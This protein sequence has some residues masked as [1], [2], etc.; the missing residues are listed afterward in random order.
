MNSQSFWSFIHAVAISVQKCADFCS[1]GLIVLQLLLTTGTLFLPNPTVE[2]THIRT[3]STLPTSKLLPLSIG[4]YFVTILISTIPHIPWLNFICHAL[5]YAA[6]IQLML[7]WWGAGPL[8]E[9][10]RGHD[11]IMIPVR[12]ENEKY[13]RLIPLRKVHGSVVKGLIS[14]YIAPDIVDS[15]TTWGNW[16]KR[17]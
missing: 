2:Y 8:D 13:E 12:G 9:R 15:G 16:N 17:T 4:I 3:V 6:E 1:D 11:E 7:L 10:D 14:G 5:A